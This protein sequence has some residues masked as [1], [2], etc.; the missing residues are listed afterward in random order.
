V[1]ISEAFFFARGFLEGDELPSS[2]GS[3]SAF[4]LGGIYCIQV[5]YKGVKLKGFNYDWLA[6]SLPRI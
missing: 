1:N 6:S 4:F 3:A 2:F 5:K